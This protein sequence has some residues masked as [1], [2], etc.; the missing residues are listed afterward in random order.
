M[1]IIFCSRLT[2]LSFGWGEKLSEPLRHEKNNKKKD[3]RKE[4]KNSL[5]TKKTAEL[6]GGDAYCQHQTTLFF[7]IFIILSYTLSNHDNGWDVGREMRMNIVLLHYKQ[8]HKWHFSF[9]LINFFLLVPLLTTC[10]LF[11]C[12]FDSVIWCWVW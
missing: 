10:S 7:R 3:R 5:E 4:H 12:L 6:T 2:T 9:L 1:L 8:S 11:C